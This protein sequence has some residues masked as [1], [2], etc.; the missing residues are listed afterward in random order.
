MPAQRSRCLVSVFVALTLSAARASGQSNAPRPEYFGIYALDG[1]K[2]IAVGD[3]KSDT[4]PTLQQVALSELRGSRAGR[5]SRPAVLVGGGVHFLLFD[6]SPA[7]AARAISI[8]RLPFVRNAIIVSDVPDFRSGGYTAQLQPVNLPGMMRLSGSQIRL[9]QKP[10]PSQ[11]QMI[12]LVPDP[13]LAQGLYGVLFAPA[14][15]IPGLGG[16]GAGQKGAWTAVLLVGQQQEAAQAGQC[17]DVQLTGGLGGMLGVDS[18]DTGS[19]ASFPLLGSARAPACSADPGLSPQPAATGDRPGSPSGSA[20]GANATANPGT[21][22]SLSAA[23]GRGEDAVFKVTFTDSSWSRS[24]AQQ[25]G[26]VTVSKTLV[27]FQPS[28]GSTPFSVAP[29]K[30]V[31]LI[32]EPTKANRIRLKVAV[33][34][35]NGDKDDIKSYEFYHPRAFM[36]GFS[37]L[38]EACDGS[39]TVL[40]GLLDRVRTGSIGPPSDSTSALGHGE[41]TVSAEVLA[42]LLDIE[43]TL[44]NAQLHGDSASVDRLL[45]PEFSMTQ[46]GKS[47]SRSQVVASAKT[48]QPAI[49]GFEIESP[50]AQ[51]DGD[52]RVLTG[53]ST[54]QVRQGA[55]TRTLGAKFRDVFVQMGGTWLLLRSEVGQFEVAK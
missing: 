45:A 11:P 30:I 18:P 35:K 20:A 13:P 27:T 54:V 19:I 25:D 55:E 44:A 52:R 10:V 53:Y 26:V 33:P 22:E 36:K 28:V 43:K 29:K 12:E 24:L 37:I 47:L 34:N 38:C 4:A 8:Y 51:V 23:V 32:D 15:G 41:G 40:Y 39:M 42:Q 6:V 49:V 9:L 1:G 5:G 3:G 21:L 31:D 2:L 14:T 46:A 48:A 50:E 16:E 17:I 7:E